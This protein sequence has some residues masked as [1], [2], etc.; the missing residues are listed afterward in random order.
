MKTGWLNI[1]FCALIYFSFSSCKKESKTTLFVKQ[2]PEETGIIFTNQ[3]N[4]DDENNIMTYQYT[5]NGGGVATGDLNN[6][7]LSDIFFIGNSVP[8]K[9]FLNEGNWKFNDV[10]EESGLQGRNH[11]KT[12]VTLVDIN[13]DGWLDIY[14]SYSGNAPVEGYNK[15]IVKNYKPRAN[16]LFINK[17]C[18]PG[19]VP[20]FQESAKEYGLDAVGTFSSQAYF[21][22]YDLDGDLDM[23]LLNHANMF[24]S[25]FQN[26][27]KLRNLRH[28]YF[29]NRIYKNE[30]GHFV[31]ITDSTGIHGSGLNFGL[32]AAISDIN[33][34]GWPDIYVTNDYEE[35]DFL[36][37]NKKDGSFQEISHKV[38]GHLSKFGMGSDIADI[39]N[40]ALP[41]IFVADMLPEDN[42]RQKVL[43]GVDEYDKFNKAVELG[44]HYQY[45]RNT[46]QL[47]AGL[48]QDSL[49][50]FSEIGQ[51]SGVSNTDWSWAPLIADFNNDGLKD[52]FITNGFLRDFTNLDFVKFQAN[53]AMLANNSGNKSGNLQSLVQKIPT[54]KV[55]NYVF[56]NTGDNKFENNSKNWGLD[57]ETTSN[58]AA[59]ADLD[60]DGD[61]DL[62]VNNLN[63]PVS[64]YKNTQE[65]TSSNNFIK[66]KLKGINKN[67]QGLGSKIY[68]TLNK[69][70]Q[71]FQ[72]TYFTRGYLS[73]VEPLFTI[74]L[75]DSDKIEKIKV[76]WPDNQV[77]LLK[78]I[79]PNQTISISQEAAKKPI[80]KTSDTEKNILTEIT[81]GSGLQFSH[82]ENNYIDFKDQRLLP[83]QLSRLGGTMAVGDINND[84]ND[85]VFF[86]GASGQA[87][88]LYL[89]TDDGKLEQLENQAW[90]LKE[91]VIHEDVAALFFD[92]DGDEDLDLYVVSGGSEKKEGSEY[93]Q[94][95]LYINEG[96]G[97]FRKDDSALPDI[98]FSGGNVTAGDFDN[99]GDLDLFIGGRLKAKKYP[100]SPKSL[101]LENKSSREK[102]K[103][104]IFQEEELGM[105][106]D[107]TWVDIDKDSIL[108]L[109]VVGEWM[110]VSVY[111]KVNE[112]F[113][114]VSEQYS[115]ENTSGLWTTIEANDLDG[116]GDVDF[117]LGNIG[118]N[119]K[120][121]ASNKKPMRYYIQDFNEDGVIDPLLTYYINDKSYPLASR[122]ELLEQVSSFRKHFNSYD[123]YAKATIED[124]L[125]VAD[126]KP[127]SILETNNLESSFLINENG[128]FHLKPL[129][130]ELQYSPVQKFIYDDITGN[131]HKNI[132]AAG[133]F[134]PY[135]VT[136]GKADASK[137]TILNINE[138]TF[139]IN[140]NHQSLDFTGDIRDLQ[141]L[142]FKNAKKRIIISRN[143][144]KPS[145]YKV[146]Y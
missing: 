22:D 135:S 42:Y 79:S 73:S 145:F 65:K 68:I 49:P 119:T 136:I 105:V 7:G 61:L 37:I 97:K 39:N 11:W 95:R 18:E 6:D 45:M 140:T 125:N 120:F 67:T 72:E 19:G 103:F 121:A 122:D 4:E 29:G 131:G 110:P 142:N 100:L 24:Y 143:D 130:P 10:S 82:K 55:S 116:D 21:F 94:D 117:L 124:V 118:T 23:F 57:E 109:V 134:F 137:G 146:N 3:I 56:K 91:E 62:I 129:P 138:N 41:D 87:G 85:D 28:P 34:D 102:A 115:L 69:N 20:T 60:N 43:D 98:S 48:S 107:A 84:G 36:Y 90:H 78:N 35:Q 92:A 8:N 89:G 88:E 81:E 80:D 16:Q 132:L 50:G 31:D 54:T 128:N 40:D 86:G 51:F 59:Y 126:V 139:S 2:D 30:E 127:I 93:Y 74:G 14:I 53:N 71:I 96:E 25:A 63:E 123:K 33:N 133:N 13:A 112:E 44:Y 46:L 75:G 26:V 70:D 27:K 47:N 114:N 113:K 64:I 144:D 106:T 66:I 52:I 38:F 1:I 58:G 32:S 9:L 83:Y 101:I 99:D 108:E 104:N 5:Y 141:I 77:S 12:G 17:G 76:V 111:K 15:P